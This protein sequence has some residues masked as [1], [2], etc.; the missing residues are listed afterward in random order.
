MKQNNGLAVGG[1]KYNVP[2]KPG[3][4]IKAANG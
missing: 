3:E 2:K 1:F 4:G